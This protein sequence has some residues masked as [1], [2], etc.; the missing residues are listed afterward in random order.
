MPVFVFSCNTSTNKTQEKDEIIEVEKIKPEEIKKQPK[1]VD[2]S[3]MVYFE[4]GTILIGSENGM[5]NEQLIFE[6]TIEPFY[7]DKN[8]VTVIEFRIF[9][10]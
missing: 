6:K 3:S 7:L 2:T 4:G 8:L 10:K 9:V 5:P 1:D